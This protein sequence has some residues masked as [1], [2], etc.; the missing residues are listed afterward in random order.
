M[1][2]CVVELVEIGQVLGR[3]E[4][5]LQPEASNA[6]ATVVPNPIQHVA[7]ARVI[8]VRRV[9]DAWLKWPPARTRTTQLLAPAS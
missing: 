9:T 2:D 8:N 6:T 4:D 3:R 1:A 7:I 5:V